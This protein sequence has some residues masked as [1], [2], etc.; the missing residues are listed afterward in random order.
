MCARR[1]RMAALVCAGCLLTMC[2]GNVEAAPLNGH[3]RHIRVAHLKSA[4][5]SDHRFG[6][7]AGSNQTVVV[8]PRDDLSS[9]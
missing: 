8:G 4:S 2:G 7:L 6:F 9:K 1:R 3:I 5:A